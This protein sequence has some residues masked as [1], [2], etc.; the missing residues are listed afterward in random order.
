MRLAKVLPCLLDHCE[1]VVIDHFGLPDPE[2]PFSCAGH[3]NMLWGSDWPWTGFEDRHSFT[4][5]LHWQ[6]AWLS[7]SASRKL[8]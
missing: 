6:R 4:D 8:A 1:P 2:D 7:P 5:T 3:E